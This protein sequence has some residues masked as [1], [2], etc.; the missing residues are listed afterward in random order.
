MLPLPLRWVFPCAPRDLLDFCPPLL[1]CW[2]SFPPPP[3]EPP[4]IFAHWELSHG[5][6]LPC[7]AGDDLLLLAVEALRNEPPPV[8]G[9]P[10]WPGGSNISDKSLPDPG[11]NGESRS[12][13][14]GEPPPPP[15][16]CWRCLD[17]EGGKGGCWE[18]G[19]GICCSIADTL[20]GKVLYSGFLQNNIFVK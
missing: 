8:D 7:T 10:A 13:S 15:E 11:E 12:M 16:C 2:C 4:I 19:G 18:E 9:V 6:F 20:A 1:L 17:D 5:F 14:T 3:P